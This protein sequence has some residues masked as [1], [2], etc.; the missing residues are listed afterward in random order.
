MV[1]ACVNDGEDLYVDLTYATPNRRVSRNSVP[2]EW[3]AAKQSR[4]L[5]LD[6][7]LAFQQVGSIVSTIRVRPELRQ[8]EAFKSKAMLLK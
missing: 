4:T 5:Q 7:L 2:K 1:S 3:A 8:L 6:L